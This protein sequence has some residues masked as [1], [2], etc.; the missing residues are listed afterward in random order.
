M[1]MVLNIKEILQ[2]TDIFICTSK[3]EGGPIALWEAMS[4]GI[5]VVSTKVGGASQYIKNGFN[6]YLCNIFDSENIFKKVNKLILNSKLRKKI[7]Y[8]AR[9]T[10]QFNIDSKIITRKYEKLYIEASK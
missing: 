9:K 2:N 7:G 10:I 6:G 3:S 5:P 1:G 8:R 4:M